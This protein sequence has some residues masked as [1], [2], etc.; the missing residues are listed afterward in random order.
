MFGSQT[1]IEVFCSYAHEDEPL[2]QKL[3]YSEKC[4]EFIQDLHA[5]LMVQLKWDSLRQ[6][7]INDARYHH[8]SHRFL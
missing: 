1:P 2:L 7:E 4:V 5:I 3:G 6:E 8:W